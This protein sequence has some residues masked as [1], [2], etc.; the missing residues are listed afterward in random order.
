MKLPKDKNGTP[1]VTYQSLRLIISVT[2]R[3]GPADCFR[4]ITVTTAD[5]FREITV[6][7]ADRFRD[8]SETLGRSDRKVTVATAESY[9]EITEMIGRYFLGRAMQLRMNKSD[10]AKENSC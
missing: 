10:L 6:T 1:S 2:S 9:R 5:C 7:T 8:S 3:K 4:E